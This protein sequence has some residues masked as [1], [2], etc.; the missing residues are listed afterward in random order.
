MST[1]CNVGPE[2]KT[3]GARHGES[4]SG[5]ESKHGDVL[6]G[7]VDSGVRRHSEVV[8]KCESDGI[9]MGDFHLLK[10]VGKGSFGKVSNGRSTLFDC[11]VL[12]HPT[13]CLS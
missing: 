9:S 12:D 8:K 10:T 11:R 6:M 4:K 1:S 7:S 2:A 3:N 13:Q 5:G